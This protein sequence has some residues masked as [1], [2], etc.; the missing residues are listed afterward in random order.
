MPPLALDFMAKKK[1]WQ[2]RL[3]GRTHQL[4]TEFV[5]SLDWDWRLYRYDIAGSI[6]HA[7]MLQKCGLLSQR[8]L[9]QIKR[10]LKAIE[11]QI[12]DGKFVFDREQ[13]D[14]HMVI[15][16][17]LID[18]IGE[19]GR[20]L[21]TGRSRNDQ[22]SLDLRMWARDQIVLLIELLARLQSAHLRL[23]EQSVEIVMPGY[24]HL[25]RAQPISAAAPLL[26]YIE[27][28]DRDK[29]R[30]ADAYGRTDVLPLGCGA[31]A[32]SSLP[33]DRKAV[34]RQ[35]G[36]SAIAQNSV[37]VAGD[38]DFLIELVF[39]CAM[40]AQHLSRWAEDWIIYSSYEFGFIRLDDAFCTSSSMMPQKKN[41]DVLE[42]IRG[43]SAGVY[44]NLISLLTLVKAQPLAYN[45]DLQ[46]DK[47]AVFSAAD[48]MVDCLE[49]A[50]E[51]VASSCFDAGQIGTKL[52]AGFLD[53][54]AMAEY[55]VKK[56]ISFRRA[57]QVV[58]QLVAN[59]EQQGRSL[60]EMP[61]DELR[62][63]HRR[64]DRDIFAHLGST[65]AAGSYRTVGAG[66][67]RECKRQ[68]SRWKRKGLGT[69]GRGTSRR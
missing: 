46:E 6:A 69:G 16:A 58:G 29:E 62:Q 68:I 30:L 64:I 52:E 8:E 9:G 66:S 12:D 25:Q 34:A 36:F 10:G 47:P 23:A 18:Q 40:V 1:Q 55:L 48:T 57:H 42:L 53:A 45:R 44:G 33:L 51:V 41:A 28:L 24:T 20:K 56:G 5:Q 3:S 17:A 15:E 59:C 37:D 7:T 11:R 50:A 14:I 31:V 27:Q 2:S 19:A 39:G 26:A 4:T 35:L 65:N 60:A 13:E 63:M 61:L 21:H 43:K 49:I 67:P 32:G 38:R 22:V 54:T